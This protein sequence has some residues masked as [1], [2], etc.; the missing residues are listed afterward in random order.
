MPFQG[1]CSCA[2]VPGPGTAQLGALWGT[3]SP[4]WGSAA[5]AGQGRAG[6]SLGLQ[7]RLCVR[8]RAHTANTTGCVRLGSAQAAV[9]GESL[10]LGASPAS[11][12]GGRRGDPLSLV[13]CC[14]RAEGRQ[15]GGVLLHPCVGV[16]LLQP[17]WQLCSSEV[18]A[19]DPCLKGHIHLCSLHPSVL[20][21]R[22]QDRAV[23]DRLTVGVQ[24]V[25][26]HS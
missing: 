11:H 10:T 5:R 17:R 8:C 15:G 14:H 13:Q 25:A 6:C 12:Q 9:P 19:D 3:G 26:V 24:E 1:C 16:V 22:C 7:C 21:W 18:P 4:G 20:I 2:A 23:L